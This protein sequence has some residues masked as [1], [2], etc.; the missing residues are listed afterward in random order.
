[1]E[2]KI[3]VATDGSVYSSNI[4]H[5]L[6]R[7]FTDLEDI[8]L[9]FL[10]I[11]P[12]TAL[13]AGREWMDEMDVMASIG[14][15]TNRK[16]TAAKRFMNEASLQLGR[17]GIAPEQV[18]TEVKLSRIGVAKDIIYEAKKGIYD[19]L[20]IGRRGI[21]KLE[22]LI[23]GSISATVLEGSGNI[24]VW[25][26]DGHVDSRKFLVP[27]DGSTHSLRAVDHLAY[28]LKDN[29]F[30]EITL[31]NSEAM[32]AKTV[33]IN[34]EDFYEQWTKEWVE[35]HLKR[36]DSLFHAPT[37]VLVEG[38]FPRDKIHH[39]TTR[40]GLYPSRQIVRQALID[41]FGTIVLGR[42]PGNISKGLFKTVSAKVIGMAQD[43]AIW[44][45]E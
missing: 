21:S 3:L 43:V 36:P 12:T 33:P 22:E 30:A 29:P 15:E 19:A 32:F 13:Q 9:H 35:E 38:G 8:R 27:I 37:Q 7:L 18:T 41:G 26:I 44:I 5:Y 31:L 14:P 2:K 40:K 11:V 1:M 39:F 10:C 42:R 28:I 23:M 6:S 24:P 4:I 45:V 17:K 34:P 16:F 20:I 25:I